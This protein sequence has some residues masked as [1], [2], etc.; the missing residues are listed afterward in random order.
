MKSWHGVFEYDK[1]KD[2]SRQRAKYD[3]MKAMDGVEAI[4]LTLDGSVE[5]TYKGYVYIGRGSIGQLKI[6]LD[7]EDGLVQFLAEN[8]RFDPAVLHIRVDSDYKE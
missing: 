2:K 6:L 5:N 1:E 3:G 7:R 8:G 4:V